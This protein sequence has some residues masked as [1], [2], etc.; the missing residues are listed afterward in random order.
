MISAKEAR[1]LAG[2]TLEEQVQSELDKVE[3]IIREA[4]GK[5]R[6]TASLQIGRAHV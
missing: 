5:G 1:E 3:T 4:A 6:R 2:P